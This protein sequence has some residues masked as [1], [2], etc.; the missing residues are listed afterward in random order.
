M[1]HRIQYF[2]QH[3]S[4]RRRCPN[5]SHETWLLFRVGDR[6][7]TD[8]IS[9][10]FQIDP[11]LEFQFVLVR[12]H[13][14]VRI[15]VTNVVVSDIKPEY[16]HIE[17]KGKAKSHTHTQQYNSSRSSPLKQ[18]ATPKRWNK[19]SSCSAC[20]DKH[21]SRQ[22]T[23]PARGHLAKHAEIEQLPLRHACQ[24]GIYAVLQSANS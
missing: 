6:V 19:L 8:L 20:H 22:R 16:T 23:L 21:G 7:V 3:L 5:V 13:D 9:T 4:W 12:N 11:F 24:C 10:Y 17:A 1:R 2:I 18:A 14:A 15:V